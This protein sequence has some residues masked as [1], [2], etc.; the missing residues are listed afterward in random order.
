MA[1]SSIPV[2][3]FNP[4]QVFA[5]IGLVEA[6]DRLLGS[7]VG[8]FDWFG[9]DFCRFRLAAPDATDPL[10]EVFH[11]LSGAEIE[12][13]APAGCTLATD[14]W[15]VPTVLLPEAAAFPMKLPDSPATLPTRLR[16]IGTS[17]GPCIIL[18]HWGDSTVRDN[19]KFWAGAAGYPGAALAKDA[20]DYVRD[21]LIVA[22]KDPF[23][24]AHPQSSSFRFDWRRDY[25]PLDAGFSPNQ[26]GNV[27]MIGY[28]LVELL[29]AIGV[30][31]A[32]PKR[33][34]RNKL[35]YR[36]SVPGVE[37]G[38]PLLDLIF[39]RAVLGGADL[40]FPRRDFVMQL[41]WPGQENQARCIVN[42]I[43]ETKQ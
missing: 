30:G 19:V 13:L 1:G 41:D 8:G 23:S 34:P 28:P 4:G 43:E 35:E 31:N 42:V 10:H 15:G 40:G 38:E 16:G 5:C 25:T 29:A 9:S 24:L 17:D 3:L 21:E 26:H 2:D 11:W 36:Y 14:K 6:A 20:L 22:K 7:C 33:T 18:D 12:A 32:R 37:S 27:V 39:L